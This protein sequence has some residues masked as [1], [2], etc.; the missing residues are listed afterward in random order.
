MKEDS[1]T[2]YVKENQDRRLLGY[3][4]VIKANQKDHS[5]EEWISN[6]CLSLVQRIAWFKDGKIWWMV[7]QGLGYMAL[8]KGEG[9]ARAWRQITYARVNVGVFY[10][11]AH[12]GY[13]DVVF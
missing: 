4:I 8:S 6:E 9:Q 2:W 11:Q 12:K 13:P 7:K 10:R 3:N 5:I 1:S